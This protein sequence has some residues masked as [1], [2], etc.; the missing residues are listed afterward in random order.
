VQMR[1][2]FCGVVVDEHERSRWGDCITSI[3]TRIG[4][5]HRR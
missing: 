3:Q 4:L 2:G 5:A 1:P